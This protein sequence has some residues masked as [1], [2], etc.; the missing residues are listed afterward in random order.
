MS[1]NRIQIEELILF[2]VL[3]LRW[4]EERVVVDDVNDAK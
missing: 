1:Q 4:E 2:A 3:S